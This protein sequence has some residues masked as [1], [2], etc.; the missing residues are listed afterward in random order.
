MVTTGMV[1]M[2]IPCFEERVRREPSLKRHTKSVRY[3]QAN[4]GCRVCVTLVTVPTIGCFVGRKRATE[5]VGRSFNFPE[6]GSRGKA[7]T[8]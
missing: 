1:S 4:E 6:L 7:L 3:S 2:T 5:G 8:T